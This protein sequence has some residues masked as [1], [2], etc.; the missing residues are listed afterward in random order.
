MSLEL[1]CQN[2][3]ERAEHEEIEENPDMQCG[4]CGDDEWGYN[5]DGEY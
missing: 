4:N 1:Y 3:G 5:N 2:C